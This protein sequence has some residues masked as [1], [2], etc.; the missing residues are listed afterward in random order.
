MILRCHLATIFAWL[1]VTQPSLASPESDFQL[2]GPS[3]SLFEHPYY[4][5]KTN[6]YVTPA[7][8]D[9]NRGV[10]PRQPWRTL[11]HANDALP[12][13]GAASGSCI[14]VAPGIYSGVKISK[15]GKR[16]DASGYV[17]YRCTTMDACTVKAD[18]GEHPVEA[19]ETR[20]ATEGAPP[21]YVMIDG[22]TMSGGNG[23]DNG[24]GVSSWNGDN[25][26]EIATHHLWV[27]NSVI[28]GF[29]QSGI[30]AAAGEFYY[31]IH[32]RIEDNSHLQ[33]SYQG[34]GVAI[35]VLHRVPGYAPTADDVRNPNPL[36]GPS[37]A[38]GNSFFHNVLEWNV[39]DNN[40]LTRC[41]TESHPTDTDGNG[42]IF[43]SNL[44]GNGDTENYAAPS[45]VAFNLAFNNGGGGIHLFFS[46]GVTVAN[47][48][49]YNN[50]TDPGNGGTGRACMDESF[51]Y[52]DRFINNIAIA[53]PSPSGGEC[54][55]TS[56]PYAKYNF[57]MLGSPVAGKPADEFSHNVTK[58]L[59]K[60]CNGAENS[61]YNGDVFSC[62][63]DANRCGTDPAWV[64]VRSPSGE[65][66]AAKFATP[67]FALRPGSA[68]IS[69]GL[70][71][72][73]LPPQSADAGA[74][75]HSAAT[76]N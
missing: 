65:G 25:G 57:A 40:G 63:D 8:R 58:V 34:S 28:T 71:E 52:G 70:A 10:S 41:G 4:A 15:G 5:C 1:I 68:A 38:S 49:C 62:A 39:I 9:A 16:A 47:N 76:C 67:N 30:G 33:C 24:V 56:P 51:G 23:S 21:N 2:P 13:G 32:N 14:N 50:Q 74:C 75:F 26:P 20:R 7:G 17:V 19:F 66:G 29:G 55:P 54:W 22:F 6:Y 11:Q 44:T 73:Y 31:F 60:T 72:P 3:A 59:G 37:W 69:Y 61:V 48:T 46:A 12:G 53:L 18:G 35:N 36:L 42:I 45:L 43:D 27:L 64:A